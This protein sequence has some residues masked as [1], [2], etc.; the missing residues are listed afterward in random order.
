M[1]MYMHVYMYV[2]MCMC[3]IVCVCVCALIAVSSAILLKS[4]CG[5]FSIR[6]HFLRLLILGNS[7]CGI[8]YDTGLHECMPPILGVATHYTCDVL[9]YGLHACTPESISC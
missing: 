9:F 7:P 2:H 5:V 4:F 1:Y 8:L 3:V 6:A